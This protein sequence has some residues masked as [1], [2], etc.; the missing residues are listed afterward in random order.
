MLE[1]LRRVVT[2]GGR[3]AVCAGF[4][5]GDSGDIEGRDREV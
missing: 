3:K 1:E 5:G 4:E 2:A